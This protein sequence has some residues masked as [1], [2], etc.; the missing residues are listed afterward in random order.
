M[1]EMKAKTRALIE[2]GFSSAKL[3][4]FDQAQRL[5]AQGMTQLLQEHPIDS[6]LITSLAERMT[7]PT[8]YIEISS[9]QWLEWGEIAKAKHSP[10]AAVLLLRKGLSREKDKNFARRAL[11]V[12]G[13]TCVNHK[14]D[15]EEGIKH[16]QKVIEM[17]GNDITAKQAQKILDSRK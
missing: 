16:L 10:A 13:E 17:N 1:L 5:L 8:L 6:D 9:N 15:V 11:F 3:G 12:L 7:K 4:Q 2:Q 14:I